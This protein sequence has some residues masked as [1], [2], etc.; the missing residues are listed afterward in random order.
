MLKCFCGFRMRFHKVCVDLLCVS[1]VQ[2]TCVCSQRGDLGCLVKGEWS[3]RE[4]TDWKDFA[5]VGAATSAKVN[6]KHVVV[7]WCSLLLTVPS[8]TA[9]PAGSSSVCE[10]IFLLFVPLLVCTLV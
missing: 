7:S 9:Q 6:K 8:T 10:L 4:V 2:S 1:C 5:S 3:F